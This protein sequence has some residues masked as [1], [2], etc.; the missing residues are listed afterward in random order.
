MLA[1]ALLLQG[2]SVIY[3]ASG[4]TKLSREKYSTH[5]R[6]LPNVKTIIIWTYVPETELLTRLK[7][8]ETATTNWVK[9]YHEKGPFEPVDAH[10]AD[11]VLCFDQTNYTAIKNKIQKLPA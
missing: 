6:R 5:F 9:Q 8:R 10:E 2:Q 3:D 4:H 1:T 11:M 7:A